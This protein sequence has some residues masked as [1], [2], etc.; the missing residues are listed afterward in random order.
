MRRT[1]GAFLRLLVSLLAMAAA[2]VSCIDIGFRDLC[3]DHSHIVSLSIRFDWK[4]CPDACPESMSVWFYS[5]DAPTSAPRR[6][7][8]PGRDGGTVRISYGSYRVLC[9]NAD[10]D[11]ILYDGETSWDG[12]RLHTRQ[13]NDSLVLEPNRVWASSVE[14]LKLEMGQEN[15]EIVFAMA[16]RTLNVGIVLLNVPNIRYTSRMDASL[17]GM[18]ASVGVVSSEQDDR[19]L[20][21]PFE[22]IRE[23]ESTLAASVETFGH[24]PGGLLPDPGTHLLTLTATLSDGSP[25]S[26]SVDVTQEMHDPENLIDASHLR[27][28]LDGKIHIPAPVVSGGGLNPSVGGWDEEEIYVGP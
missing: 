23:G 16:P 8:I 10:T 20:S 21:I 22:L 7:D 26:C 17:S 12:F 2:T 11:A 28:V 6:Y 25:W 13:I 1:P 14:G 9:L 19:H 3:Y 5:L 18:S 24:C 27:I 4:D 15:A